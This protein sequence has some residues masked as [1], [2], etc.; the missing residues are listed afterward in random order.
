VHAIA[1]VR[2]LG[3]GANALL[4]VHAAELLVERGIIEV[5]DLE[6]RDERAQHQAPHDIARAKALEHREPEI[7]RQRGEAPPMAQPRS[8]IDRANQSVDAGRDRRGQAGEQ[9]FDLRD[10]RLTRAWNELAGRNRS[11]RDREQCCVHQPTLH[12]LVRW[13]NQ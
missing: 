4:V 6:W 8:R 1:H 12:R 13:S 9:P 11:L 10:G 2:R 5:R 3:F 7:C